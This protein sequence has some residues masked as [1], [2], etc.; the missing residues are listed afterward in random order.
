MTVWLGTIFLL[1]FMNFTSRIYYDPKT[2]AV[3][4]AATQYRTWYRMFRSGVTLFTTLNVGEK[5]HS[6]PCQLI[7]ER[8]E[9]GAIGCH[10][11]SIPVIA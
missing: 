3:L 11:N 10:S 6:R 5:E 4:G 1:F 8:E 2:I 7:R 9:V